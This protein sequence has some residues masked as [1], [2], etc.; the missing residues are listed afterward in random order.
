M[1]VNGRIGGGIGIEWRTSVRMVVIDM[2]LIIVVR[3]DT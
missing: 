2:V 3:L 1:K